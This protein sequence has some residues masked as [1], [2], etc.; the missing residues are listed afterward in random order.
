MRIYYYGEL[1]K[2]VNKTEEPSGTMTHVSQVLDTK[3]VE[4]TKRREQ[5]AQNGD[6]PRNPGFKI[7]HYAYA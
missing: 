6:S 7:R 5:F 3:M 2:T 4:I 1:I